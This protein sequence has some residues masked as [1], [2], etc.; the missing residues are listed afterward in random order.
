MK[1]NDQNQTKNFFVC[2]TLQK[3]YV[4]GNLSDLQFL[5]VSYVSDGGNLQ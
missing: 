3:E 4:E 2:F 1:L 5:H